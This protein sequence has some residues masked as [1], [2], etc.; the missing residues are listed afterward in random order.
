MFLRNLIYTG[1]LSRYIR[2]M[3]DMHDL[4]FLLNKQYT[5][6]SE[7]LINFSV[8]IASSLFSLG[9]LDLYQIKLEFIHFILYVPLIS[10]SILES[11]NLFY[12]NAFRSQKQ[13]TIKIQ[14]SF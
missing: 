14:E 10:G 3:K 2:G 11:R 6:H 4:L 13:Q 8:I 7:I 12:G 9:L 5:D 1:I